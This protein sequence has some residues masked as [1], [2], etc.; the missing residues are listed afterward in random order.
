MAQLPSAWEK[1]KEDTNIPIRD[2][3]IT[4][5]L[6]G[7]TTGMSIRNFL[8][9]ELLRHSPRPEIL[10]DT[11][12]LDGLRGLAAMVVYVAHHLLTAN[13]LMAPIEVAFGFEGNYFLVNL[14]FLRMLFTGSH[15]SVPIFFIASGFVQSRKALQMIHEDD[16]AVYTVLASGIFRRG[17]RLLI[18]VL[19]TAFFFMTLWHLIGIAPY[20]GH[21]EP[22]YWADFKYFF[23]N[24]WYWTYIF[25]TND[26]K[27]DET[28]TVNQWFAYNGHTWTVPIELQGSFHVFILLLVF[29]KSKARTRIMILSATA[30]YFLLEGGVYWFCFPVGIV[31]CELDLLSTSEDFLISSKKPYR[32]HVFYAILAMGLYLGGVPVRGF[33][34]M[35]PELVA[36][37]PG[38]YYLSFL[39]PR[40]YFDVTHFLGTISA[41][42]IIIAIIGL[43]EL[44]KVFEGRILQYLGRISFSLYLCHGPILCTLGVFIYRLTGKIT[45]PPS[46]WD[47]LV[48][49][50]SLGPVGLNLNFLIVNMV[51]LPVT[52]YTSELCM[53]LFDGPSI[54]IAQWAWKAV[55]K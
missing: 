12:Y 38:F 30:F 49:I 41:F 26:I 53:K 28:H 52:L 15:A 17:F 55:N 21:Y 54:R 11:A 33:N 16:T 1:A 9:P 37:Q 18:P 19:G 2:E 14:P 44:Q 47:S 13:G 31:L 42:L 23:T 4:H 8:T 43:S 6:S 24:M 20:M 29:S 5:D 7:A 10:R 22:T 25:K 40:I 50:P 35:S 36:D 34:I 32:K 46:A 48:P 27:L 3:G 51:V 45:D 39:I